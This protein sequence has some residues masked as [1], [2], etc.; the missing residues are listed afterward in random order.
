M[1]VCEQLSKRY[2]KQWALDGLDLRFD[3][4]QTVA[5]VGPNG[6]GKSTFM[7][8]ALGF[9]RPTS[10]SIR[11]LDEDP[12]GGGHFKYAIGYMPQAF[13]CPP[14]LTVRSLFALMTDLRK[15]K[16]ETFD[17]TLFERFEI[18]RFYNKPLGALSGGM[19]QKVNAALAF[20]FNPKI[21]ILDEPTA[22]LDPFASEV[23]K[24]K[25]GVERAAGKLIIISSHIFSDLDV[26][27]TDVLYLIDGKLQFYKNVE[28]LMQETG[29]NNLG[30]AFA[31]VIANHKETV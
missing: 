27:A 15:A 4:G 1:I 5:L 12:Q 7:K 30:K 21:Y 18:D 22:G 2:K 29:T 3:M 31:H 24:E 17:S 13:H 11:V 28:M 23:L 20:Y 10:G 9:I 25:I 26:L 14:N 8:L 6:S 16:K 19:K